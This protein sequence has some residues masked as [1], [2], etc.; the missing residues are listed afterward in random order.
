MV[1]LLALIG[2]LVFI[3]FPAFALDNKLPNIPFDFEQIKADSL[4][5]EQY[6]E[7]QKITFT[8]KDNKHIY[9]WVL[10]NVAD[11]YTTNRAISGGYAKEANPFLPDYPSL[12]RLVAQKLVVNYVLYQMDFFESPRLV[13]TGNVI[14]W[15]AVTNNNWI[16]INNE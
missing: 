15:L 4:L 9:E 7:S 12:E 6:K 10:W 8:Q 14:G 13:R 5:I 2:L 16:I 1:R 11:V 3:S